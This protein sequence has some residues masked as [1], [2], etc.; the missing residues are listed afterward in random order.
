MLRI[1]GAGHAPGDR[2]NGRAKGGLRMPEQRTAEFGAHTRVA[3]ERGCDSCRGSS[4]IVSP[5]SSAEAAGKCGLQLY[6]YTGLH[7]V[8]GGG[9]YCAYYKELQPL[10]YAPYRVLQ[11]RVP[12]GTE[13]TTTLRA[14]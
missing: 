12:R 10:Q 13:K 2:T 1:G 9:L 6:T 7:G 11:N 5:V 4:I 3:S 14:S 8:T